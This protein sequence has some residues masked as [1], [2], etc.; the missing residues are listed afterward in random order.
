MNKNNKPFFDLCDG[1]FINYTWKASYPEL[2]AAVAGDRKFDVYMGIDVFGRNTYGGGQWKA[3]VALDL[4]KK[5]DISAA[6]FAPGWVYETKQPPDFQTAQNRWWGLVENSW[7]ILKRYP[8]AL[9]FYSNFDQGHGYHFSVEGVKVAD[10]PWNNISCQSIQPILD[11]SMNS[12]QTPIEVQLNFKNE[13]YSGGGSITFSGSL[14]DNAI[15]KAR[16]FLLELPLGNL[17]VHISYSVSS[18]ENSVLALLFRLSSDDNRERMSIL[19]AAGGLSFLP[20]NL[21]NEFDQ[22]TATLVIEGKHTTGPGWILHEGSIEMP[23]HTLTEICAVCYMKSEQDSNQSAQDNGQ[24]LKKCSTAVVSSS[25]FYA[26][27]GHISIETSQNDF[28]D[29]VSW[30]VSCE[31][32]SWTTVSDGTKTVS[33]KITW[34]LKTGSTSSLMWYNIFVEKVAKK[35][36]DSSITVTY[37]EDF[38]GLT[39]LGCYYVSD[40]KVP[41]GIAAL[42]FIIQVCRLDGACQKLDASPRFELAVEG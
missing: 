39:R 34:T 37:A 28:P 6:I 23:G 3:N 35:D 12:V 20:A 1:I 36:D 7:G 15:F 11:I 42:K 19:L 30:M 17:P 10:V 18:E 40:L 41:A 32:V 13:S 5:V 8:K 16:L 9:P 24:H 27:L 21:L 31:N 14:N 2:S 29:A 38:L 26:S 4:L 33:T 22:I 25:T